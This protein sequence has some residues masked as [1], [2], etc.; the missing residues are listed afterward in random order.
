MTRSK[1]HN[2]VSEMFHHVL[3]EK[4]VKIMFE[5]KTIFWII[6]VVT[7]LEIDWFKENIFGTNIHK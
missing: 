2:K 1:Y 6:I 5:I 3:S 4:S 7:I